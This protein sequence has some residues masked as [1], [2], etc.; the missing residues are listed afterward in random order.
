MRQHTWL[1]FHGECWHL[2]TSKAHDPD[3]KWTNRDIALSD[4]TWEGW[5]IDG[6]H[7]KQPTIQHH[8]NRHLYG[9]GLMRTIH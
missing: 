2:V 8:A 1:D 5:V 6:P 7:G 3:R 4:L 9:Y